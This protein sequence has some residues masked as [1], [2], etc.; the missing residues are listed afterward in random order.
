MDFYEN[1]CIKADLHLTRDADVGVE[2][3][4]DYLLPFDLLGIVFYWT[5]RKLKS[6]N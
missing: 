5:V 6:D 1:L 2:E 3:K 4:D